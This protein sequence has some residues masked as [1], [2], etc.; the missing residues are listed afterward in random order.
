MRMCDCVCVSLCVTVYVC[1]SVCLCVSVRVFAW[2]SVS[3]LV[4]VHTCVSIYLCMY[5][6]VCNDSHD[7][8]VTNLSSTYI[9]TIIVV[10]IR[11]IVGLR[12]FL[13]IKN[14]QCTNLLNIS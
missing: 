5:Y 1:D 11:N 13:S 3:V 2:L 7:S 8:F 9:I 14:Y 12:N 6:C 10:F 4:C